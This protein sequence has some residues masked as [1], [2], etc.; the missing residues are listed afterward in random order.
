[1]DE[2]TPIAV[3]RHHWVLRQPEGDRIIGRCKRC[4][5]IRIFPVAIE[6]D[7]EVPAERDLRTLSDLAP[8]RDAVSDAMR[9]SA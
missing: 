5:E 8:V 3:C 2:T 9:W 1:M 4:D 7:M 6:G